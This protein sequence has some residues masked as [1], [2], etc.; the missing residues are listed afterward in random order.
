[1]KHDEL[2]LSHC[3]EQQH[4][5]QRF[6]GIP[7]LATEQQYVCSFSKNNLSTANAQFWYV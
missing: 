4:D 5:L 1:L 3:T 6:Q 2:A 7:E